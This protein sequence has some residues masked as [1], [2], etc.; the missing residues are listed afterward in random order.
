[1]KAVRLLRLGRDTACHVCAL[2]H[3]GCHFPKATA[4]DI[5]SPLHCTAPSTRGTLTDAGGCLGA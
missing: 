3:A 1:M 2:A 4:L 5:Q